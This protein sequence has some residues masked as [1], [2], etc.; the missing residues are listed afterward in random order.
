[1]EIQKHDMYARTNL[2]DRQL[3]MWFG[4]QM[5]ANVPLFSTP[6]AFRLAGAVDVETFRKAFQYLVQHSDILRTIFVEH[7]GVPF[8]EVQETVAYDVAFHDFSDQ[9]DAEAAARQWIDKR[10]Q[11]PLNIESCVFDTAL[12]KIADDKYLWY[13]NLHH[14]IMDEWTTTLV[15]D[16][17]SQFYADMKAGQTEPAVDLPP[18][19][20]YLAFRRE[21]KKSE[22]FKEAEAFWKEKLDRVIEPLNFYGKFQEKPT[23]AVQR[24]SYDLGA[25]R[26]AKLKAVAKA[27]DIFVKNEKVTLFN[28]FLALLCTYLH[29]ISGNPDIAFVTPFHNRTSEAFRKTIGLMIEMYPLQVQIAEDETFVS[30]ICKIAAEVPKTVKYRH[31]TIPSDQLQ[32]KVHNVGL[33]YIVTTFTDFAGLPVR[34]QR[35]TA[36]HAMDNF[37]LH[38]HDD[39]C[40]PDSFELQ[41]EFNQQIFD[42]ARREEAIR[43]FMQLLDTFIDDHTQSIH[44]APML[45]PDERQ[46]ILVDFNDTEMP[47]PADKTYHA[48]FEEVAERMPD[49]PA[50]VYKDQT[51]TY[52]ELNARA[53]QLAHFLQSL[54]V[55]PETLVGIS[56]ERSIEMI[57]SV[58]GI[59][60]SGGAYVPFDPNY[61]PD[62]VA[63]MI[64]DSKASVILTQS[65]V[66]DKLPKTDARLICLDTEWD[67]VA[68]YSTEN[69]DSGADINTLAY[70]I[71]TSGSTGKP[72]GVMLEHKGIGNL[73]Q[74]QA[75]FFRLTPDSHS[76]QFASLNF[77]ASI[78]EIVLTFFAGATLYLADQETLM[79]GPDFIKMMND[80]AITNATLPPS[81]MSALPEDVD[82]PHLKS[83]VTA[84]E[85]CSIDLAKRW[86]KGRTMINGYGPTETTVCAT[87]DDEIDGSRTPTIGKPM[88]N[89]QIYILDP[90]LEPVPIGMPGEIHIAGVGLARGYLNRPDLTAQKFIPNPFS[91]DPDAL[92]YKS[93]DLG[94]WLPDGNID[95]LGRIDH[96]VKIRGFRIEIGEIETVMRQH[97]T[98]KEVVIIAREDT[99]GV[100]RLVAYVVAESGSNLSSSDLHRY[101]KEILPDYMVPSAFVFL[102]KIP[103]TPNLKVDRKALPAPDS[104]RVDLGD[105]YV[106]PQTD[107]EKQLVG[108]WEKLFGIEPIGMTDNFFELGGHSLLAVRMFA[109]VEKALG[110]K[111]PIA[112]LIEATTIAEL[113][114][115][116]QQRESGEA[117]SLLVPIQKEGS[118]PPI[119]WAHA[120]GGDILLNFYNLSNFMGTDYP[121]YG[122]KAP[123]EPHTTIEAMAEHY[124]QVMREF[125]PEGPYFLAGYSFGGHLVYE[126]ARQLDQQGQTVA[127]LA[128]VDTA[129]DSQRIVWEP[130]FVWHMITHFSLWTY[131][132]FRKGLGPQLRRLRKKYGLKLQTL[133]SRLGV[134]GV[135]EPE[136]TFEAEFDLSKY[137]DEIRRMAEIHYQAMLAYKPQPYPGR[138]ALFRLKTQRILNWDPELGWGAL[139]KGGVDIYPISDPKG[140]HEGLLVEP[141]VQVLSD[142]IKQG[143]AEA[144]ERYG[145]PKR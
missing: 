47:Y 83:L 131:H 84:G 27:E 81:V 92:M 56:M 135:S 133:G 23:T 100:K 86:A 61:P 74:Y 130:T 32:N 48:I 105:D 128:I 126:M 20:D 10:M 30:L 104:T 7:D 137:P 108:I 29:R 15:F 12:L 25:E 111:L 115:I 94:T 6:Y 134:P 99:P 55:G 31:H 33:N 102:E 75:R 63:Y 34:M 78:S 138:L 44:H 107:L 39:L 59:F 68:P 95:F 110:H 127:L 53:N 98:V 116:I 60:K 106:A 129:L 117:E 141:L 5:H 46:K 62:R 37:V 14:A 38:F 90:H 97:D 124:V 52:A 143:M 36:G 76:L 41:F 112:T 49:H 57:V 11:T 2:T 139:A 101:L 26:T 113:S 144:I 118:H 136:R 64:E 18:Y 8:Q 93:G 54:G 73:A 4:H 19:S 145:V 13:L 40:A 140:V 35:L 87:G 45:T 121:M 123:S 109:E 125:Q 132:F 119:F 17:V 24:I 142:K 51:L 42:E 77:D 82:F 79:P 58:L 85:A 71:Y 122:I 114:H 28:V 80:Y 16:N 103:L 9:A 65:H 67:A 120:V 70:V 1:M 91:D 43:H 50:L 3:L 89:F 21:L 22:E 69:P 96:Q 72:K 66:V 88:D